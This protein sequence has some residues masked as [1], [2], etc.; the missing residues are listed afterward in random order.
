MIMTVPGDSPSV[1]CR[2]GKVLPLFR[3][4]Q[5]IMRNISIST[6]RVRGNPSASLHAGSPPQPAGMQAQPRTRFSRVGLA[7]RNVPLALRRH[8][9]GVRPPGC[10]RREG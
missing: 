3:V 10:S 6:C 4:Q 2:G 5:T 7:L 8:F 9:G 1:I